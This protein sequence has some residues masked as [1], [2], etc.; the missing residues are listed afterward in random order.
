LEIDNLESPEKY[1]LQFKTTAHLTKK[2]S[3]RRI[4]AV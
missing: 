3:G 4:A 1:P 2:S